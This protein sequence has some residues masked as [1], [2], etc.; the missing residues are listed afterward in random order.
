MRYTAAV[1]KKAG[2]EQKAAAEMQE[3]LT[4]GFSISSLKKFHPIHGTTSDAIIPKQIPTLTRIT[5]LPNHSRCCRSGLLADVRPALSD[6]SR[7]NAHDK[8]SDPQADHQYYPQFGGKASDQSQHSQHQD[9]VANQR[10][11]VYGHA[12]TY[13]RLQS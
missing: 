3:T 5:Y 4:L 6:P 10:V 12:F 2:Q 11:R 1:Q 8:P 13:D 7:H 9:Y